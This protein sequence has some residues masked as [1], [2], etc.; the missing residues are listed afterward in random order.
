MALLHDMRKLG[1]C[2]FVGREEKRRDYLLLLLLLLLLFIII[3][4][5]YYSFFFAQCCC[6]MLP[7]HY[8]T[9]YTYLLYDILK[10]NRK[11]TLML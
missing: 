9:H 4:I 6:E 11:A 2:F 8:S 1:Y 5:Y 7:R 10:N 3:I